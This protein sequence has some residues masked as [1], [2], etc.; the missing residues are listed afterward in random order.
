MFNKRLGRGDVRPGW[1]RCV[2]WALRRWIT[3]T[4]RGVVGFL[5]RREKWEKVKVTR[6]EQERGWRRDEGRGRASLVWALN[7]VLG[8]RFWIA[9]AFEVRLYS[10]SLLP[11]SLS[12][13]LPLSTFLF[14]SLINLILLER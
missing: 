3:N 5:W 14:S 9:G 12:R 1:V 4:R 2:K 11:L 10:L 7:D 8:R 6:E 13:P